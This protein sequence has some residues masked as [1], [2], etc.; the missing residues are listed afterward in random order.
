MARRTGS[1]IRSIVGSN[2]GLVP[3]SHLYHII[4]FR[5]ATADSPWNSISK[6]GRMIFNNV[7]DACLMRSTSGN[8]GVAYGS[9]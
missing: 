4:F 6:D 3:L 1:L 2:T 8:S 9:D 5:C 7:K